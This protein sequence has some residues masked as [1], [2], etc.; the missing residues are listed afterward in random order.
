MQNLEKLKTWLEA[1]DFNRHKSLILLSLF[2]HHARALILIYT[3]IHI[4]NK[5]INILLRKLLRSHYH[6]E[7]GC[8]S[9]GYYFRIPH[10][11]NI[12]INAESIGD[13]VQIN[14]NVTLGN[15]MRKSIIRNQKIQTLPIIGNNVI[16]CANSI[17]GGPIIIG[18][19]VIIG[20]NCTCTHDVTN[21]TLLY[22]KVCTST[23]NISVELGTYKYL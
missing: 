21:N 22:N 3:I 7:I 5:F 9:I 23:K 10:P 12:I 15:N 11:R 4:N 1:N 6:I 19:N 17:V 16:I 18:D 2:S 14:Q 13:N 20:S 8:Q